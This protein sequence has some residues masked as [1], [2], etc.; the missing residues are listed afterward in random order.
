MPYRRL[1]NWY[2]NAIAILEMTRGNY[3]CRI[4]HEHSDVIKTRD[5]SDG[6]AIKLKT[7]PKELTSNYL[8][9]PSFETTVL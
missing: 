9:R 1:R 2:V 8:R 3:L 4:P 7:V 6:L 5:D